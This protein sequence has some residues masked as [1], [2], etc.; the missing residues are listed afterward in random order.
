MA[1]TPISRS[2][3]AK[4]YNVKRCSL[5]AEVQVPG[6][7]CQL[8][9]TNAHEVTFMEVR[10]QTFGNCCRHCHLEP[11]LILPCS[12]TRGTISEK[13]RCTPRVWC[14]RGW[15]KQIS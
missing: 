11:H 13:E 10:A 5:A 4:P 8:R 2:V 9:G 7:P 3:A 6:N 12:Y 1:T 15:R 14:Y